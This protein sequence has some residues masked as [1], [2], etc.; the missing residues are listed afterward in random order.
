[1]KRFYHFITRLALLVTFSSILTCV[2]QFYLRFDQVHIPNPIVFFLSAVFFAVGCV[3]RALNLRII[4]EHTEGRR[5]VIDYI[6]SYGLPVI[7]VVVLSVL[8]YNLPDSFFDLFR[9]EKIDLLRSY[10]KYYNFGVTEHFFACTLAGVILYRDDPEESYAGYRSAVIEIAV[11]VLCFIANLVIHALEAWQMGSLIVM[12]DGLLTTYAVCIFLTAASYAVFSAFSSVHS[13]RESTFRNESHLEQTENRALAYTTVI[14]V[15]F[16]VLFLILTAAL[17]LFLNGIY[18]IFRMIVRPTDF[19]AVDSPTFS[20]V[21]D[22]VS[23]GFLALCVVCGLVYLVFG[24]KL[25]PLLNKVVSAVVDFF[26]TAIDGW[27]TATK[28]SPRRR[29]GAFAADETEEKHQDALIVEYTFPVRTPAEGDTYAA[30][31]KRLNNL[32]DNDRRIGYAYRTVCTLYRTTGAPIKDSD[33]PREM[34]RKLDKA[35]DNE[36]ETLVGLIERAKFGSK[37]LD[38][39]EKFTILESLCD[40]VRRQYM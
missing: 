34:V 21:T 37:I 30:F 7:A 14:L 3:I 9:P 8:F 27:R 17:Y 23:M 4:P 16:L 36:K 40:F 6:T 29:R 38:E 18:A 2:G 15:V 22:F 1:M 20:L 25:V 19:I 24:R 39:D 12:E 32:P 26:A 31:V 35:S 5:T 33:T 28:K 13:I 10:R 11:T